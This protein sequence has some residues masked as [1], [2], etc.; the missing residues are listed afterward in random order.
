VPL[1]APRS[2]VGRGEAE[3]EDVPLTQIRKTIA[4]RLVSSLG[5]VPHFFLTVGVGM[6]RA[7]EAR[8][9]LTR[10]LGDEAKVSFNHLIVKAT[11]LAL[12]RHRACNAWFQDDHIRYWNAVHVGMAVVVEDGLITPVARD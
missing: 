5:P 10:D 1:P 6:E 7:A 3:Y 11:A 12:V 4:R 8:E 9:A 2:P